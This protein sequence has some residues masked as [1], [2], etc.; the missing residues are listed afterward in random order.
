[1]LPAVESAVA[2]NPHAPFCAEEITSIAVN[3]TPAANVTTLLYV[4]TAVDVSWFTLLF[5]FPVHVEQERSYPLLLN[6][7]T[8]TKMCLA[9]SNSF[10]QTR[11]MKFVLR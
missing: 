7:V 1:M 9:R 2:V 3:G 6:T 5:A 8:A 11:A 4:P 10:S